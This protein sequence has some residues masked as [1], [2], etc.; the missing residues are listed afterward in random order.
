MNNKNNKLERF[1]T[2][3]PGHLLIYVQLMGKKM[4]WVCQ[5][6]ADVHMVNHLGD[7]VLLIISG[8]PW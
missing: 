4:R 6:T 2:E 1:C 8:S 7:N 3:L 5:Q